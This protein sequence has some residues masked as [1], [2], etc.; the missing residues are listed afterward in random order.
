MRMD[1]LH[2]LEVINYIIPQAPFS[3]YSHQSGFDFLRSYKS[4]NNIQ[5]N[6]KFWHQGLKK[7]DYLGCLGM[8]EMIIL[9]NIPKK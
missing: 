6:K 2:N 4:W 5:K 7:D 8:D 3:R 9:K 1:K